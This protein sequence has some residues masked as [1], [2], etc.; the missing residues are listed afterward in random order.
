MK[1]R[2]NYKLNINTLNGYTFQIEMTTMSKKQEQYDKYNN[3]FDNI[4]RKIE[5]H[6]KNKVLDKFISD[7][8]IDITKQNDQW[9]LWN[10][11]IINEM[12]KY[13]KKC[14]ILIYNGE[15]LTHEM[16]LFDKVILKDNDNIDVI[17]MPNPRLENL[18][19]Q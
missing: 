12:R 8:N 3:T 2:I 17:F 19:N 13:M 4:R 18:N 10:D 7:N 1:H 15:I 6:Y 11:D 9:W 14:Q 5:E 16:I